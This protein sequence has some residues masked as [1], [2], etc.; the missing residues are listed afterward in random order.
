[1]VMEVIGTHSKINLIPTTSATRHSL[2]PATRKP[3]PPVP[4]S[5]A[6]DLNRAVDS[7]R[8]AFK[9]W[10]KLSPADRRGKVVAL[11]EAIDLEFVCTMFRT[12]LLR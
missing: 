1:V 5:T 12:C 6:S 10:S 2:N 3:N 4:V 9:T 11:G 8:A 7:A